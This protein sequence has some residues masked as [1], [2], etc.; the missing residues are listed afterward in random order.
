MDSKTNPS[1]DAVGATLQSKFDDWAAKRQPHEELWIADYEQYHGKYPD[2][3]E[4]KKN[5]SQ[6]FT[7]YTRPKIDYMVSRLTDVLFPADGS[8]HWSIGST[9]E[10]EAAANIKRLEAAIKEKEEA[11]AAQEA[12]MQAQ[13]QMQQQAQQQ[14]M[15]QQGAQAPQMAPPQVMPPM[16]PMA[17]SQQPMDELAIMQQQKIEA[18]KRKDLIEDATD[19]MSSEMTDQLKACSYQKWASQVIFSGFQLGTGVMKGPIRSGKPKKKWQ[20]VPYIDE[21]TGEQ[22]VFTDL[23]TVPDP[24][25]SF[26][27]VD[28]WNFYPDPAVIDGDEFFDAFELHLMNKSKLR[29]LQ[30]RDGFDKEAIK[31]VLESN[32]TE[33]TPNFVT[34]LNKVNDGKSEL[35]G[36]YYQVLEYT[37]CLE[38]SDFK[39]LAEGTD[40]LDLIEDEEDPLKEYYGVVWVCN[41]HVLKFSVFPY[42]RE[43]QIYR[44]FTPIPDQGS[45][46]GYSMTSTLR[47]HQEM[48]NASNRALLDNQGNTVGP[49]WLVT[50]GAA[51]PEDG[52]YTITS[53]KVWNINEDYMGS[54]PPLVAIQVDS[55]Q[56]EFAANM[57][58]ARDHMDQ[59]SSIP[60][61]ATGEPTG[62]INHTAMGT[63]I[64]TNQG[65]IRYKMAV[66]MFD[67]QIT[68]PN[69]RGLYDWNMQFNERED[70]KGDMEVVAM[71]ASSL[72]VRE[73]QAQT[74]L[75]L[76]MQLSTHPIYG[77]MLKNKDL[78]KKVFE[79]HGVPTSDVMLSDDQIEAIKIQ[80]EEQAK[81]GPP[82][83]PA[84]MLKMQELEQKAKAADLDAQLRVA[85]LN[86]SYEIEL[87]KRET[88]LIELASKG[89]IEVEKLDMKLRGDREKEMAKAREKILDG[90]MK[91]E[92]IASEAMVAAQTGVHA[93]GLV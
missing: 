86:K 81:Q 46:F 70:I 93:G 41:G 14:Q 13:M 19:N 59:E 38:Y 67:Q 3:T 54:T 58:I 92:Q 73:L 62:T 63:A 80:A 72:L 52:E 75:M 48:L 28:L 71:G 82:Q 23:V 39:T 35:D 6:I 90:Q 8:P 21:Q 47:H 40:Q 20:E 85:E 33:K 78:L 32:S 45:L 5:A 10:P 89:N 53:N 31:A 16:P 22:G 36:N 88:R 27:A 87:I 60:Q 44:V 79:A 56:A 37:G 69:I 24:K 17:Q 25:P 57:A 18:D 74:L 50:K 91:Q 84:A 49:Q 7:N 68:I 15:Q 2:D 29:K 34:R 77:P 9:P 83:D 42:D 30:H 51:E 26:K 55:R 4:F 11:K 65:L 66:S 1:I 64:L 12:Q 43:E 76:T 61:Q